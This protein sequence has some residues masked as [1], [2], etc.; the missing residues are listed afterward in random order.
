MSHSV[1][2]DKDHTHFENIFLIVTKFEKSSKRTYKIY[3]KLQSQCL[4]SKI[5]FSE[6]NEYGDRIGFHI[7]HQKGKSKVVYDKRNSIQH[8]AAAIYCMENTDEILLKG[9]AER[10]IKKVTEKDTVPWSLKYRNQKN[11]S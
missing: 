1:L 11:Q 8:V 5:G 9:C 3:G 10:F 7:L 6:D 2:L 4:W